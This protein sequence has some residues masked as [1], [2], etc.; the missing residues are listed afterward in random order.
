M[1][2]ELTHHAPILPLTFEMQGRKLPI[3]RS[4]GGIAYF[5]FEELCARPLGSAD[6]L[7]IAK[8]FHTVCISNI[9]KLS[10]AKRN[11]ARRFITLIDTLYDHRVKLICTA[12]ALPAELY[13]QGDGTFEFARTVSRL[14]EMQSAQYLAVAHIP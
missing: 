6:Y 7:A 5:T 2:T 12:A 3:S 9:P 11:E 1:F 14:T 13:I 8:R 10:A 4:Y